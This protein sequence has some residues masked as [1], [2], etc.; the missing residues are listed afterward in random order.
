MDYMS[1]L[2]KHFWLGDQRDNIQNQI[3]FR[4]LTDIAPVTG[5][6]AFRMY[7]TWEQNKDS[8]SN[9]AES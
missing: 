6:N 5:N 2:D 4:L 9:I 1:G 3:K 7:T 8:I